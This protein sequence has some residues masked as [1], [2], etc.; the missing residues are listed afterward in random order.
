M[1]AQ[2]ECAERSICCER[3]A[4]ER[5]SGLGHWPPRSE[6][7]TTANVTIAYKQQ[8]LLSSRSCCACKYV[9]VCDKRLRVRMRMRMR[10]RVGASVRLRMCVHMYVCM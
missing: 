9:C 2:Y 5:D 8:T 6:D 1:Q 3:F 7:V 10:M 4:C